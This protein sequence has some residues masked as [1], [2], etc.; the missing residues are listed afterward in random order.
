MYV[1][2][3]IYIYIYTCSQLITYTDIIINALSR[4]ISVHTLHRMQHRSQG[5]GPRRSRAPKF[6][7]AHAQFARGRS[8]HSH[9]VPGDPQTRPRQDVSFV[10]IKTTERETG[11]NR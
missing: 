9:G 8:R 10:P 7:G 3:Y 6:P 5:D 2:V 11:E 1:C 4:I